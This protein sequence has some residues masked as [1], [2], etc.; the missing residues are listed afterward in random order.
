MQPSGVPI[1]TG[2][3]GGVVSTSQFGPYV[4]GQVLPGTAYIQQ[5]PPTTEVVD[6]VTGQKRYIGP[7][8][9]L[10]CLL[11]PAFPQGKPLYCKLAQM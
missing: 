10:M 8:E 1:N 9:G 6:P 2:A 3:G 5:M 11:P 4:P 7:A